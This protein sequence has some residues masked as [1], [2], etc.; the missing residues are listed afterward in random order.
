MSFF[1]Q[2]FDQN[3]L[4]RQKSSKFLQISLK[5]QGFSSQKIGPGGTEGEIRFSELEDHLRGGGKDENILISCN[6][7]KDSIK[8]NMC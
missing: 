1:S 2:L 7:K 8:L 3:F 6:N 5:N 4:N